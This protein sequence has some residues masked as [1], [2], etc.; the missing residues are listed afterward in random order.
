MHKIIVCCLLLACGFVSLVSAKSSDFAIPLYSQA[1]IEYQRLSAG[2][3]HQ[4]LLSTP[5][6]INNSL[7]IEKELLLNGVRNNLLLQIK[8]SGSSKDAF[9][10]YRELLLEQ[11][12][13]SYLCEERACGSSNYWANSIFNESKL[14]GRDSQQ[15][16]L[17]GRLNGDNQSYFVSAYIVKNGRKQQYIYL[18]YVPVKSQPTSAKTDQQSTEQQSTEQ[19]LW[20]QGVLIE[21]PLLNE[22]QLTFIKDALLNDDDLSLWVLGFSDMLQEQNV[23]D[24]ISLSD[25]ALKSFKQD[26]SRQLSVDTDRIMVKNIGPFSKKPENYTLSTWYQLYLLK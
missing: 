9:K 12:G 21:S 25:K 19:Q 18:S 6:R 3:E 14:Y 20:E 16:Y 23:K 13:V 7:T 26:V 17:A 5:K 4:F 15:Y 22:H 8:S 10:F 1:N 2:D 11:G 24:A